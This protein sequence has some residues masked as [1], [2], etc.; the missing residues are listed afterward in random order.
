MKKQT[1]QEIKTNEK[2]AV[3]NGYTE[4]YMSGQEI[5]QHF[6]GCYECFGRHHAQVSSY[7]IDFDK[8]YKRIKTDQIYRVFIGELFCGIFDNTTDVKLYFFGY[9]R[10]KPAWAKD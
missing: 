8:N 7:Q 5:R 1:D 10:S 9:T 4:H 3:Y 6:N 2:R